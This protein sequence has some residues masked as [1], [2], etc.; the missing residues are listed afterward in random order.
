MKSSICNNTD[1]IYRIQKTKQM[2]KHNKQNGNRAI[3]SEDKK[4]VAGGERGE[5]E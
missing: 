3:D 4:M 1:I 2:S 5:G